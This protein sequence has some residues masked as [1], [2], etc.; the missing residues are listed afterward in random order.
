MPTKHIAAKPKILERNFVREWLF[1]VGSYGSLLFGLS[2]VLLIWTGAAYFMHKEQQQ[3]EHAAL[4]NADNLARAFEEHIIRSI[5]SVDQT[6]LYVRD[7]YSRDPQHFNMALWMRNNEFLNGITFQIAIIDKD[8][9]MVASNIPGSQSGVYLGDREHFK[10]HAERN[11]DELFVSKPVLGRVSKKWSIQ[12]T[13]RINMPDGS[14]GGVV[15]V[16]VD[17]DYLSQFYKSIDVGEFGSVS[18]VGTDG[19]VRARAAQGPS[20]VGASLAKT[21]LFVAFAQARAG[22][23]DVKSQLDGIERLF[24]YRQVKG[25]PLIV[26]VGLATHEIFGN[27]DHN[28]HIV[29]GIAALLTAWLLGVTYLVAQYQSRLARSRDAAEAGTRARSEFLAMMSHEIR[30]PMNGVIGMAEVLLE[31]GLR[32][33][34]LPWAKTMRES[35]EHLLKIINDVLDFSKLEANRVEIEQVRIRSARTGAQHRRG[36]VDARG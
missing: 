28:R 14:F 1:H 13:R 21:Q 23:Y 24:V 6:L 20:T 22:F 35:A 7:S 33:D 5:R 19:I 32:P 3:T 11:T 18:L 16:S 29:Y 26:V 8:G 27:Y 2:A 10:V 12:L 4:Q 31:S 34:Q 30:T 36:F 9:V 15:V 25:Y 17:P